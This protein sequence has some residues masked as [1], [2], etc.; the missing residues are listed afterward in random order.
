[1]KTKR[2]DRGGGERGVGGGRADMGL[3]THKHAL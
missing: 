2:K 1:M 3:L